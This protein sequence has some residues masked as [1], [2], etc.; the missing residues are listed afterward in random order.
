MKST[1]SPFDGSPGLWNA[2]STNCSSL[3]IDA[4]DVSKTQLVT[5]ALEI[6]RWNRRINLTGSTDPVSFIEGPLFDAMTLIPVMKETASL[7]DI[8]SGGGLPGIPAIILA[9]QP[10]VTLVEPR[11]KRASFL[12][13]LLALLR[14]D[15]T[16]KTE[17][18]E[19]LPPREWAAAVAQAVFEPMEWIRRAAHILCDDGV[20]YVLSATPLPEISPYALKIEKM[21]NCKTLRT[22]ASR[23]AYR[24]HR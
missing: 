17:R 18:I 19:N 9:D 24:L 2:V 14:L 23:Y 8:G 15:A 3:G 21:F 10:N 13:H 11:A 1:F 22:N 4:A 16:V 12:R 5:Y 20:I 6:C 7:V